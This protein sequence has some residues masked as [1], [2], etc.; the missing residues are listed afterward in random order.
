MLI[1]ITYDISDDKRR[2]KIASILEGY[3]NRVNFSVF[4]CILSQ[5]KLNKLTKEIQ[6]IIDKKRQYSLLLSLPKLHKK[7][8]FYRKKN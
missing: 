4:E 3:G 1:L 7:I 8:F 2:N 6:S 5:T